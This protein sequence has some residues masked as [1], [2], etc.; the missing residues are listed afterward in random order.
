[1]NTSSTITIVSVA[2]SAAFAVR[3]YHVKNQSRK[4]DELRQLWRRKIEQI[5][6]DRSTDPDGL[7]FDDLMDLMDLPYWQDVYCELEK[8]PSGK[9]SLRKAIEITGKDDYKRCA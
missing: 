5:A 7:S 2:V 1:M 6:D 3:I 9:R 4:K 8:M